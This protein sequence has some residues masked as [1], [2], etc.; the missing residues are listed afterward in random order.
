VGGGRGGKWGDDMD[1]K[2]VGQDE[3]VV[4]VT[5]ERQIG[6]EQARRDGESDLIVIDPLFVPRLIAWLQDAVKELAESV[7]N[8]G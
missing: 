5:E 3:T 1:R 6:I 4:F 7:G 2:F 8:G